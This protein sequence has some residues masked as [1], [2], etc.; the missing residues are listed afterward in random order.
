VILV[1]VIFVVILIMGLRYVVF[2]T[3]HVICAKMDITLIKQLACLVLTQGA[4]HA[5]TPNAVKHARLGTGGNNV[6]YAKA[7][8]RTIHVTKQMVRVFVE[9]GI[10]EKHVSTSAHILV[11]LQVW[12]PIRLSVTTL[13]VNA[14]I[15]KQ[16]ILVGIVNISV[17]K[18]ATKTNA[19][20]KMVT[21]HWGAS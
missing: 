20:R 13:Q 7:G 16:D 1:A 11:L 19:L 8:V 18:A 14:H 4:K 3:I 2:L 6:R 5:P 15:V 21:V 17:A 9:R 12:A 10:L